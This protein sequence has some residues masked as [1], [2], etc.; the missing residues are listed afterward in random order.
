MWHPVLVIVRIS[1]RQLVL[2]FFN[3]LQYYDEETYLNAHAMGKNSNWMLIPRELFCF[4]ISSD[5]DL[6]ESQMNVKI[7]MSVWGGRD[8]MWMEWDSKWDRKQ[9]YDVTWPDGAN[10]SQRVSLTQVKIPT[11]VHPVELCVLSFLGSVWMTHLLT[12]F[13]T[14]ARTKDWNNASFEHNRIFYW[15]RMTEK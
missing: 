6:L 8:R 12:C 5:N 11:T 14:L 2:V 3:F 9:G 7:E 13:N 1:V 4:L 10:V 15:Q